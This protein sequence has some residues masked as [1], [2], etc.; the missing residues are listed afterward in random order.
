MNQMPERLDWDHEYLKKPAQLTL[1]FHMLCALPH[2]IQGTS[3]RI[4][5]LLHHMRVNHHR[6][7]ILPPRLQ[8][9]RFFGWMGRNVRKGNLRL[10]RQALG[11][12]TPKPEPPA[13]PPTTTCSSCGKSDMIRIGMVEKARAPPE[14]K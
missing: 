10:I 8:K 13:L 6:F 2:N 3:R 7:H 9:I 4:S 12:P 11:V 5:Q 1:A 14:N